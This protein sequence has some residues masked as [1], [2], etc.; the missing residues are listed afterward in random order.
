LNPIR[1]DYQ[2]I[3]RLVPQLL[4]GLELTLLVA[5]TSAAGALVWGLFLTWPRLSKHAVVRGPVIAYIELVRNSPLLVQLYLLFFALPVVGIFIPAFWCGVIAIVAQHG[6]FLCETY[7][8]GI[9][10]ISKG[11]WEAGRSIGLRGFKLFRLVI[12]P[13]ALLKVAPAM[14]NQLVILVKDTSLVSAIGVMEMTLMAKISIERSAA[15]F[16]VFVVVGVL[17]LIITTLVGGAG[18]LLEARTRARIGSV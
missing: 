7:R 17:Y 12:L 3:S 8:A 9:E 10:S 11:Q 6:A 2:L 4:E 5:L 16:E 14:T 13:Q 15:T 1:L 18:R